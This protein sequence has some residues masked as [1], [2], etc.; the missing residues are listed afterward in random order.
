VHDGEEVAVTGAIA[1]RDVSGV[2]ASVTGRIATGECVV[3]SVTLWADSTTPVNV[4]LYRCRCLPN[5]R[6][7]AA[8][9]LG[10]ESRAAPD[11]GRGRA[12]TPT[13]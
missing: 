4:A 1:E 9:Y 2:S 10:A 7:R 3:A 13:R 11:L 6:S 5:V 8:D 12:G